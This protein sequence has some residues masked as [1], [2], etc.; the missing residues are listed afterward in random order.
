MELE[1]SL[2]CSQQPAIGPCPQLDESNLYLSTLFP[3]DPFQG[4]IQWCAF[5]KTVMNLL[6]KRQGIP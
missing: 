4:R 3:Y 1:V 2:P 6:H 5:V